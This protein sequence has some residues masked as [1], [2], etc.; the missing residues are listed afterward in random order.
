MPRFIERSLIKQT[1][2]SY[3]RTQKQ[4]LWPSNTR[5][6]NGEQRSR[7]CQM[8]VPIVYLFWNFPIPRKIQLMN[9]IPESE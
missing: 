4:L 8:G 5:M 1:V 7:A 3:A 9:T 6:S 2:F